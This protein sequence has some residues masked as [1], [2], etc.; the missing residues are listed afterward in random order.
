MD[1]SLS[2]MIADLQVSLPL[3]DSGLSYSSSWVRLGVLGLLRL[4]FSDS[5]HQLMP[6]RR[7]LLGLHLRFLLSPIES[8]TRARMRA[9]YFLFS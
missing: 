6:F 3:G 5:I 2:V 9:S 4:L 7:T 8:A 1:F